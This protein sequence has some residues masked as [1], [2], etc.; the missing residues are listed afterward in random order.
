MGPVEDNPYSDP[1]NPP[2]ETNPGGVCGVKW[3]EE[4]Q[5]TGLRHSVLTSSALCANTADCAGTTGWP[6]STARPRLPRPATA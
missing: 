2:A 4:E 5:D 6:T 3:A 1:A